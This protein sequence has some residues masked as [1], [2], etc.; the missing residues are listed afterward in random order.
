MRFIELETLDGMFDT[1]NREGK[2]YAW[3]NP[4]LVTAVCWAGDG[5]CIIHLSGDSYSHRVR[6]SVADVLRM[7]EDGIS[8]QGR[9]VIL[10]GGDA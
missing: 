7:I 6:G 9:W 4:T 8:V 2:H 3:I 10:N 1:T 5:E